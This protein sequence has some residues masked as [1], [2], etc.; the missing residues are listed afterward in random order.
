MTLHRCG[1]IN[2]HTLHRHVF[3]SDIGQGAVTCKDLDYTLLVCACGEVKTFEVE[4]DTTRIEETR[5]VTIQ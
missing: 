4:N 1:S 5:D 3:D 2:S